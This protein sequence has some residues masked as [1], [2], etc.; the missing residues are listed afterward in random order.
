[1]LEEIEDKKI[2]PKNLVEIGLRS[3]YNSGPYHKYV[4]EKA[5]R[6]FTSA[7]VHERGIEPVLKEAQEYAMDGTEALYVTIDVD[8]LDQTI[9]PGT[10]APSIGG[11]TGPQILKAAFEL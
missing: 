11:L 6:I 10:N 8:G 9:A 1:M 7:T 5:L 4:K 3:F 2:L